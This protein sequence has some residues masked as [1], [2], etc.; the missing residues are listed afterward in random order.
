MEQQTFTYFVSLFFVIQLFFFKLFD[1]SCSL[2]Y[3]VT[4]CKALRKPTEQPVEQ[5]YAS[6]VGKVPTR[7]QTLCKAILQREYLQNV[8]YKRKN[9][10]PTRCLKMN[11]KIS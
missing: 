5:R 11:F 1:N 6:L 10:L 2:S 7:I 4:R 3:T 9:A 8:S